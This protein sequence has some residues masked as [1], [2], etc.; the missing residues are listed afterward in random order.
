MSYF[1]FALSM[2]ITQV[3][4]YYNKIKIGKQKAKAL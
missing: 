2:A 4:G 3:Q 1:L